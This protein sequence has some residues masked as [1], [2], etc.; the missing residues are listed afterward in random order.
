MQ[1]NVAFKGVRENS[2]QG[3]KRNDSSSFLKNN[4][5]TEFKMSYDKSMSNGDLSKV[6]KLSKNNL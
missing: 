3:N 4:T 6:I 2:E 1:K 5:S